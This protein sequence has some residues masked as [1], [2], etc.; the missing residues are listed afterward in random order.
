MPD[1]LLRAYGVALGT[2]EGLLI[3]NGVLEPGELASA[4]LST[5]AATPA[6]DAN[7]AGALSAW[8]GML[9]E[10]DIPEGAIQ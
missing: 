3:H 4:L 2:L 10:P 6:E 8:A 1:A 9:E 7:A 5:A